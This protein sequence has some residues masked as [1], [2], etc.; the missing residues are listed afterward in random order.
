MTQDAPSVIWLELP[1]V[2]LPKGF[3]K[4]GFSFASF[5]MELSCR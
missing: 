4:A 2:T 3:S 5:S 1:G